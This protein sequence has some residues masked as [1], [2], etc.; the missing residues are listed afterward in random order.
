MASGKKANAAEEFSIF[1]VHRVECD[2]KGHYKAHPQVRLLPLFRL[3]A[4]V[5]SSPPKSPF[6]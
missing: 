2:V 4:D 3:G 5:E 6:P 1:P